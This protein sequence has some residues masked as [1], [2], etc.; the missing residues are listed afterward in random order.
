MHEIKKEGNESVWK[1][2]E[3]GNRK[4]IELGSWEWEGLGIF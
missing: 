3:Y 2:D 4:K 1:A